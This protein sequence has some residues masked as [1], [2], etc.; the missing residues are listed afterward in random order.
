[1]EKIRK[2]M[3]IF[4][5]MGILFSLSIMHFITEDKKIS[6]IERRKLQQQPDFNYTNVI[7]GK[8][9]KEAE[10][11]LL[12]QFPFRNHFRRLHAD[13]VLDYLR[14]KDNNDV[15]ILD[16]SVMKFE[17]KIKE[18]Q[19]HLATHKINEIVKSH[20][21]IKKAYYS[22]IPDKNYYMLKD[23][24]YPKLNYNAFFHMIKSDLKDVEYI[25]ITKDLSIKDY[26]LTDSHF[27]Q[28]HLFSVMKTFS[29]RMKFTYLPKDAYE[30][31]T[32][33][34]FLGVY[35]GF[36]GKKVEREQIKYLTNIEIEKAN[37][38]NV[39]K[40][41]YI[42]VYNEK[43]LGNIDPYDVFLSGAEPI[44]KIKNE[45]AEKRKLIIFRDSF[46]SSIAPL[47]I[48]SYSDIILVDIRYISSKLLDEYVDF[49]DAEVLFLYNTLIFN[50]GGI[51][52]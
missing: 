4:V 40:K 21:E 52:K 45:K 35:G 49:N 47:F 46:G 19:V 14:C 26:Y 6:A 29:D 42:K 10:T 51:L 38:Y 9:F 1:M 12:D 23:K 27:K 33:D 2:I 25:D 13:V 28:S 22:I 37:V 11:Y 3:V 48:S 15:Y 31:K 17:K 44:L 7:N 24:A 30:E 5:F 18:N 8:Y 36:I 41:E 43:E 20:K 39:E 50:S 34:Q 32:F 16:N